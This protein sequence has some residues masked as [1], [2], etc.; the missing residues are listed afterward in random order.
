MAGP[1]QTPHRRRRTNAQIDKDE[2]A[3]AMRRRNFTHRQ[4]ATEMGWGSPS[5]AYEAVRR[6]LMESVAEN[7]AEVRRV[8]LERLDESGPACRCCTTTS[9]PTTNLGWGP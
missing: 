1:R 5:R 8:E 4:I 3:L 2:R 6:A 9:A 7:A